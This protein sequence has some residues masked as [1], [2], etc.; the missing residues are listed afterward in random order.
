MVAGP[1]MAIQPFGRGPMSPPVAAIP[2]AMPGPSNATAM[3]PPVPH[4]MDSSDSDEDRLV[5]DFDNDRDRDSDTDSEVT[6]IQDVF[7]SE[8]E[9]KRHHFFKEALSVATHKDLIYLEL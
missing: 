5:I 8:Q 3:V 2:P 1:E 4:E 9:E 7:S 6:D